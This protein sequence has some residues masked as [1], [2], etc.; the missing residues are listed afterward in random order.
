MLKVLRNCKI[1]FQVTVPFYIVFS[2]AKISNFSTSSPA[3]VIVFI[4][5]IIILICVMV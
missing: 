3:L 5:N 4:F 1:V 2:N